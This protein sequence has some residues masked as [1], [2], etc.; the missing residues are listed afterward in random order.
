M[1]GAPG[2]A[3][4]A[5]DKPPVLGLLQRGGEVVVRMLADVRQATIRP[6]IEATVVN[7]ALVYTDEYD[8]YARLEE[9]GYGHK[10]VCHGGE[11][12]PA[13]RMATGSARSTSTRPRASGPCCA[14]GCGR[15]GASRGRSCPPISA[16]SS[17]S[18]TPG[19]AGRRSSA[20]SSPAW[21]RRPILTTPKPDKS[22][23][24]FD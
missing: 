18:T 8:I 10:T 23:G 16:S 19:A 11:S 22:R 24:R 4:L 5:K 17:S 14:P 13:T 15:T 20:P 9:W 6:V 2:R 3:T 1:R 7:G 12:T 21:S